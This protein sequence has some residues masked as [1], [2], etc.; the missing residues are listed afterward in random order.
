MAKW[1]SVALRFATNRTLIVLI[2]AIL[3]LLLTFNIASNVEDNQF[4]QRALAVAE[5]V[6][7][8]PQ[9]AIYVEEKGHSSELQALAN[10]V[11][12]QTGA[13]YIVIADSNGIRL[14]HPNPA[15]VGLR[16]DGPLLALQGKSYTTVNSGSLGRSAN[17]KTPIFNASGKIIG[18][19]SAGFLASSFTGE[20]SYLRQA[21]LLYG[22]GLIIL[23]FFLA[24]FLAR[25]LRN[26]K[27]EAELQSI[28]TKYQERE[29]MLHAIK[30]GVITLTPHNRIVLINDE[31]KRLLQLDE[32]AIGNS[33]ESLIPHGRLLD[34][35]EGE[36]HEDDDGLVLNE[37]FS[38]R[39]NRRS[40]KLLGKDIGAVITVRDRTEHIGLMRELDSIKN[41]TN[42][43]RAQQHEYSNR[44]HTLT[45]LLELQRYEEASQYLGEISHVDA[46]LAETLRDKLDDPTITA[47]LL[48]K[49]SIAREK[50]VK[51]DI[52]PLTSIGDL[53]IDQNAKITVVGNL[54]DN[55]IEATAG[56]Q[57]AQVNV[58][59]DQVRHNEKRIQVQDNGP[60][61]PEPYPQV[62]FEDGFS[63]KS[64]Q[65]NSHRGLGLA[66]VSRLVKQAAGVVECRNDDG[67]IFTVVL[68]V[69]A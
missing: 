14:T 47:L 55:A 59:F 29:A 40:V 3:G 36:V 13:R 58:I 54:I 67:A 50:G 11:A 39:V 21:F 32:S 26:R 51:L 35:L 45:G 42:A 52:S 33:I 9:V 30:E 15:L 43:L 60:G 28:R 17:G 10:K 48:A 22:I 53:A 23:G 20:T 1:K 66:I 49:V 38:L 57:S 7:A 12:T 41:L 68:P 37:S 46:N 64:L 27:I 24:E 4:K 18:L 44:M 8:I 5:S 61:L 6:A 16:I 25:R 56:M 34:L 19:V 31:A 63:T 65:A 2:A 62:V 69:N